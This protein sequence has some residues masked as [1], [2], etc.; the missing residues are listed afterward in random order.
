MMGNMFYGFGGLSRHMVW[1]GGIFMMIGGLILLGLFIYGIVILTRHREP[2]QPMTNSFVHQD[3]GN[4]LNILNE[5]YARGEVNEEE[6][7][8]KKSE[9]RK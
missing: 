8:R 2:N 3:N 1:G 7:A 5:R 4:A 6:F 9:L